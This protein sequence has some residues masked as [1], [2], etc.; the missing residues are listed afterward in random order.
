MA[1]V[2][3]TWP[4]AQIGGIIG[5]NGSGK[6]TLLKAIN[7]ILPCSGN[8]SY[9][10]RPLDLET[11]RISYVPQ[12]NRSD[13]ALSTFEMVLLGTVRQLGWRVSTAQADAVEQAMAECGI[14]ALADR[15]FNRLS[16]G[17]RQLVM[18]AQAFV[19]QPQI[20]LLDEPTS[21]LD[22]HHQL[23]VLNQIADYSRRHRCITL[24]V[25]HDLGLALRYCH[26][27]TLLEHGRVVCH[28]ETH[29]M[30]WHPMISRTFGVD[31]ESGVSPQGYQYLLPTGLPLSAAQNI[32]FS[33]GK[34]P[35]TL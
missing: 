24:L 17:Q 34:N 13:S 32:L 5:P 11:S 35:C 18:L 1:D 9:F 21:T 6:S 2:S 29:M 16:G 19:A 4:A 33:Q 26:S 28:G 8:I 27:L 7:R 15:P 12:L 3:L 31:I 14:S 20:I 10:D 30:M 22:I 25:I 23:R